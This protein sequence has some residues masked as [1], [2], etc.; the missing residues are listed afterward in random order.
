MAYLPW[1]DN[2]HASRRDAG[3]PPGGGPSPLEGADAGEF[4]QEI[5]NH[6]FS[7]GLDLHFTLMTMPDGPGR[8]RVEHAITEIDDAIKDLRHLMVEIT[9]S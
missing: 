4:G 8:D 6:L 7:A 5:S 1:A 2:L 9:S 3:V